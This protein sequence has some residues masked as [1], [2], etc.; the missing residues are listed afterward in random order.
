MQGGSEDLL[1]ISAPLW[2]P[3]WMGTEPSLAHAQ[4]QGHFQRGKW[5][6][7]STIGLEALTSGEIG[8]GVEKNHGNRAEPGNFGWD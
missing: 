5:G 8:S 6:S 3:C 2:L 1:V 4:G 7:G